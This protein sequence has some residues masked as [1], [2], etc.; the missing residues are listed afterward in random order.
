MTTSK[1]QSAPASPSSE[2]KKPSYIIDPK[3]AVDENR[4]LEFLLLTRRCSSCR[5]RLE[6]TGETPTPKQHISQI[7]KCCALKEGFIQPQMPIQE[8]IF[9]ILLSEGNKPAT[10]SHL[11][12]ILTEEWATP[13]NPK[14][15]TDEDLRRILASD[16][17]Y[18]FKEILSDEETGA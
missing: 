17:Y 12:S 4:S 14:N 1:A 8:I 3:R 5:E 7:A 15:I 10:L 11:H 18:G 13:M 9:H 16:D 2:G 6:E